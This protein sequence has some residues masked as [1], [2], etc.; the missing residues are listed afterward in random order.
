[1]QRYLEHRN[2]SGALEKLYEPGDRL[3][4]LASGSRFIVPGD[5]TISLSNGRLVLRYRSGGQA[6]D[7]RIS[8][9]RA[10]DD[11]LP[12]P[13]IPIEIFMQF[14]PTTE[15][16]GT[17]EIVLPATPALKGIKEVSLSFAG[18]PPA[19]LS[20][21]AFDFIPFEVALQPAR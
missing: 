21:T 6:Q 17:R 10:K 5:R 2:L 8:F 7:A 20:L 15:K 12:P 4:L 11:P 3:S 13:T 16:E 18:Q 14:N 1:M 19:D 9:K